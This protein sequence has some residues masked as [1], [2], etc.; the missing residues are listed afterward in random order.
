MKTTQSDGLVW[1][2]LIHMYIRT[3][4]HTCTHARAH[5]RTRAH[6]H[7]HARTHT[8]AHARTNARLQNSGSSYKTTAIQSAG[9]ITNAYT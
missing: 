3:H 6:T 2:K 1:V 5:T 4:E 8:H 9:V 7:A